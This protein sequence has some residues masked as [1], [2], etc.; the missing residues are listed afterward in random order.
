M[1]IDL[2]T[3]SV[4]KRIRIQELIKELRERKLKYPVMDYV[5]LEHQQ[6]LIDAVKLR[7][8]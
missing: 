6:E 7:K 4:E 5:P 3:L 8:K 2:D 1:K